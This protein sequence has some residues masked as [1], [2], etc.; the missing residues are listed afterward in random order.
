MSKKSGVDLTVIADLLGEDFMPSLEKAE[1]YKPDTNSTVS[2][3]ELADAMKVVPRAVMAWL[4]RNLA[5]MREGENRHLEIPFK[6][7]E[8]CAISLSKIGP[9]VYHGEVLKG[10]K[11]LYRFKYRTIPG[12]GLIV[13]TTFELYDLDQLDEGQ[14][15]KDKE[16][17][18][19]SMIEERI[20]LR[21][22]V[23]QV[24]EEKMAQRDAIEQLIKLRMS[25]EMKKEAI[26][27]TDAEKQDAPKQET[28]EPAKLKEF[29]ERKKE[30]PL[31]KREQGYTV[32]LVKGDNVSCPDCKRK[33]FDGSTLAGCVCYGSDMGRKVFLKKGEN[34]TMNV[35]FSKGW[36]P[37]NVQ[38]LL[39]ALKRRE[40]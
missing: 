2:H 40:K 11:I 39:E 10:G 27:P 22:L 26:N 8:N 36:D 32:H 13:L 33:L 16:S 24:I 20:A 1:L 34:G 5:D 7:A 37:E 12:I 30:K 23:S 19:S 3:E 31:E 15:A 35:K 18:L 6:R 29:L 21:N 9:D 4:T 14:I 25:T 28:P 38:M 17:Y